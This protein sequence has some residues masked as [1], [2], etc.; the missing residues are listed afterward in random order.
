MDLGDLGTQPTK[1]AANAGGL[2]SAVVLNGPAEVQSHLVKRKATPRRT[3]V[4]K[5]TT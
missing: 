3:S 1:D 5:I 4:V 2:A